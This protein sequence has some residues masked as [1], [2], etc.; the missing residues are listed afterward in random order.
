MRHTE[1]DMFSIAGVRYTKSCTSFIIAL[2]ITL[3]VINKY[4]KSILSLY[5]VALNI[6]IERLSISDGSNQNEIN[7]GKFL[8][9]VT[10]EAPN[11]RMLIAFANDDHRRLYKN[12]ILGCL[13]WE[14]MHLKSK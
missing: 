5:I 9:F 4:E 10:R 3:T 14:A 2:H 8:K 7:K 12:F 13:T 1:H 6:V 11:C